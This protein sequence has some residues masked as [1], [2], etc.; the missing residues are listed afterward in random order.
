VSKPAE[1]LGS[2]GAQRAPQMLAMIL[3]AGATWASSAS[4]DSSLT[5]EVHRT[6]PAPKEVILENLAGQVAIGR[7]KDKQVEVTAVIHAAGAT[8]S[9]AEALLKALDFTFDT[10]GDRLQV[11]G[12]YPTDRYQV[13]R[14][15]PIDP[16]GHSTSQST[17]DNK[18]IMVTS[19]DER[20]AVTLYA[21]VTIGLPP[22]VEVRVTEMAGE[23]AVTGVE[24]DVRLENGW[25]NISVKDSHGHLKAETGSGDVQITGQK[26]DIDVGTGSGHIMAEDITGLANLGTGSGDVTA[27][28]IKGNVSIDTGSGDVEARSITGTIA[29]D[30]GS[31]DALITDAKAERLA[32]DT[33]SGMIRVESPAI[34][35]SSPGAE[36]LLETGSGD[37]VLTI[38]SQVSMTLDFE[39]GSGKVK[40]P[41]TLEGRIEKIGREGSRR[42]KI[43]SGD[44][45]VRV[46]TGAGDV[47][48]V[49]AEH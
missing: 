43:G 27:A 5:R 41:R 24:S 30:T 19:K 7:S 25:G 1:T 21:D 4:A 34:F 36:A 35:R 31:G 8:A 22:G 42:Y 14:Y 6:F 18:R 10:V 20:G 32:V 9:E 11:R 2:G 17:Y 16:E 45:Q 46:E 26:G 47:V 15:P 40:S 13:Y 33:G 29:I 12:D 39:S 3:A 37:V 48:L 23:M 49:M 28:R 38:D 44:S